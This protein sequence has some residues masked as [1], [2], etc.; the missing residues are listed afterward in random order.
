MSPQAPVCTILPALGPSVWQVMG[1]PALLLQFWCADW[2]SLAADRVEGKEEFHNAWFFSF[3]TKLG[4]VLVCWVTK[5]QLYCFIEGSA[6]SDSYSHNYN[7]SNP[8]NY[9]QTTNMT[10]ATS[11]TQQLLTTTAFSGIKNLHFCYP[12]TPEEVITLLFFS[13]GILPTL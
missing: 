12:F 2:E 8:N 9:N 3:T 5:S 6:Y 10:T 7:N 1:S 13:I 4:G 11:T